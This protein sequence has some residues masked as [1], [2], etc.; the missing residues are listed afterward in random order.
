MIRVNLI[1]SNV[2][3]RL[4]VL[5]MAIAVCAATLTCALV[6]FLARIDFFFAMDYRYRTGGETKGPFEQLLRPH[7]VL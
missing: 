4:G 6:Y 2:V 7:L 5:E 1:A 3:V